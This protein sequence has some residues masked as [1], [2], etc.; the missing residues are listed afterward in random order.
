MA[1]RRRS[2]LLPLVVPLP[3]PRRA[4]S[5]DRV[6]R[7]LAR[8]LPRVDN[9]AVTLAS[10]RILLSLSVYVPAKPADSFLPPFS[11]SR[12]FRFSPRPGPTPGVWYPS[13]LLSLVSHFVLP[14]ATP[15]QPPSRCR[16]PMTQSDAPGGGEGG[17]GDSGFLVRN[18]Y[19]SPC[20]RTGY[21]HTR[22]P[23]RKHDTI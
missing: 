14:V 16:A 3:L 10:P 5:R 23:A 8:S 7:S 9:L 11:F 13:S 2:V 18:C 22:A 4:V 1:R 19:R 21:P 17:E 20:V 12:P 6:V 15:S